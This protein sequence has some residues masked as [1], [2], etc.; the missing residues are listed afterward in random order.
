MRKRRGCPGDADRACAAH[1]GGGHGDTG[2][3]RDRAKR[4][5]LAAA[6]APSAAAL[7]VPGKALEIRGETSVLQERHPW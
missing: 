1:R 3:A 2:C 5:V 4:D 7:A 6:D